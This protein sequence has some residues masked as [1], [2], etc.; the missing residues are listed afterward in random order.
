M[1]LV[2]QY[3]SRFTLDMTNVASDIE[4]HGAMAGLTDAARTLAVDLIIG[5]A[6]DVFDTN[7]RATWPDKTCQKCGATYTDDDGWFLY[8]FY[9]WHCPTCDP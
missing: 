4:F 6:S 1:A 3:M 8:A 2:N 7:M 9:G 5:V